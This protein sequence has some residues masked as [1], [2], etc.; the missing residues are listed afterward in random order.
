MKKIIITAYKI[1]KNKIEVE[2][3]EKN[4]FGYLTIYQSKLNDVYLTPKNINDFVKTSKNKIETLIQGKIKDVV[5]FLDDESLITTKIFNLNKDV[6]TKLNDIKLWSSWSKLKMFNH[7]FINNNLFVNFIKLDFYNKLNYIMDKNHLRIAKLYDLD[8]LRLLSSDLAKQQKLATFVSLD[9]SNL[10]I[11]VYL[12]NQLIKSD[13]IDLEIYEFSNLL[14]DKQL[15]NFNLN[16]VKDFQIDNY[17]SSLRKIVK[18]S[19]KQTLG[20]STLKFL[21]KNNIF[22]FQSSELIKKNMFDEN[23]ILVKRKNDFISSEMAGLIYLIDKPI[24]NVDNKLSLTA[25]MF[26]IDI[27]QNWHQYYIN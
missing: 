3:S 8:S 16:L 9:K 19:V 14:S 20:N 18:S 7:K 1:S 11:K 26:M 6:K 12:H 25:E 21:Q 5:I 24:K 22:L 13:I 17:L 2:V 15:L 27:K 4:D 10:K 23:F